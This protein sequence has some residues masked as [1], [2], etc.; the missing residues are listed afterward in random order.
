MRCAS[1][2]FPAEWK[3]SMRSASSA[4]IASIARSVVARGV[5]A[6]RVDGEP[7]HALDRSPGQWVEQDQAVDLVV[8]QRD[9]DRRFRVLGREDVDHVPPY[10]EGAAAEV[11]LGALVLH[12]HQPR[13]HLA[14]ARPLALAQV[15]DHPVVVD[16]IADAVYAR[17]RADDH[18]VLAL[19]QRFRRRQPHLLDVLVDAR[20]LLDVE[21]ARRDVRL[22]LVV[23]VV[24]DE[25]LDRV[26]GK[27]FAKLGVELRGERLVRRKDQRRPADPG[28][29][30]R[31]RVGLPRSGDAEQRLER[32]SVAQPFGELL[33][34]LG[35]IPRGRERLMQPERAPWKGGYTA[36]AGRASRMRKVRHDRTIFSQRAMPTAS[37]A[38]R[39]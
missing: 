5:V 3:N 22:R 30:V 6:G 15:Q 7:R 21:V 17:H 14:L 1:T 29:D 11:E 25:V 13:D 9:A 35:L 24:G 19:E 16:R 28:D 10:P 31:H 18:R 37:R 36:V 34:R 27:E 8:E 12:R 38:S 32:E 2:S 26:L 23:V 4:L 39:R 33:D 20:V